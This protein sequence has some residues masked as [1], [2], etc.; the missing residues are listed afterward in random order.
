VLDL[1]ERGFAPGDTAFY[2]VRATDDAPTGNV[3]TSPVYAL[4]LPAVSELRRELREA[5]RSVRAGADSVT[6]AQRELARRMEDLA[7]ERERS[8]EAQGAGR[9]RV[10]QMPFDAVERA[11]EVLEDEQSVLERARQLDDELR[12]LSE[13]A[14]TAGLTDPAFHQ[15]VQEIRDLLDRAMTDELEASLMAL[16]AALD[17][18]DATDTRDALRRLAEAAERL[19][20]ELARGREL[21]ERAAVEGDLTTLSADADEL[22]RRQREWNDAVEGADSVAAARRQRELADAAGTLATELARLAD[23]VDS[24]GGDAERIEAAGADSRD[25]RRMMQRA[26]EQALQGQRSAARRSGERV[27]ESLDPMGAV[28]RQERDALRDAWRQEVMAE[29]DRALVETAELARR[30]ER[31]AARAQRGESGPDVRAELAAVREGVER[32]AQRVQDAAGKNALVP[33]RLAA[34]LGLA[35][36]R[37]DESLERLQRAVPVPGEAADLAGEAVDALNGAVFALVRSR[38]AVS[39]AQSGSGLAE[40]ME[41][42]AQLAQ[43][44]GN[45]NS[46][47]GGLLPMMEAGGADLLQQLQTL[48]ARQRALARELERLEA[49]GDVSGAGELADEADRLANDLDGG[50]LDQD[51]VDRQG[52]LFRRLLDAGRSL[53]SEEEDRRE[54]RVS[55]TARPGSIRQPSATG[56]PA[57]APRFRYPTWDELRALSPEQRRLVVE[58]FRRLNRAP[59]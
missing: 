7:A 23:A 20:D 10:E 43:Q 24:L 41:R 47:A 8:L 36:H 59:Q 21:F 25:A 11:R 31:L 48:A 3:G 28:L 56:A 5:S 49:G 44:Q 38:G 33:P 34:S 9:E 1:N 50:R 13:A 15:Q 45:L 53:Q 27:S 58:Y 14:W 32:V 37:I 51:V 55:E 30:Q 2:F 54:E 22:A 26:A 42:M 57:G 35:Q 12:E 6:E 16:R 17:R 19:R 39:S 29:L 52:Q 40:A 18:L 46:E 4:R